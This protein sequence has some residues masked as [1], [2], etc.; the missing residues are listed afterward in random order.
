MHTIQSKE[1]L[2]ALKSIN[3]NNLLLLTKLIITYKWWMMVQFFS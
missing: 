2:P 1:K 3:N